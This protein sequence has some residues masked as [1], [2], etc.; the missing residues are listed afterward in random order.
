MREFR[1]KKWLKTS[2]NFHFVEG[3]ISSPLMFC[4][5]KVNMKIKSFCF[6]F[7]LSLKIMEPNHKINKEAKEIFLEERSL[8]ILKM[9]AN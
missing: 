7:A 9:A 3:V 8:Q 2:L 5:Q 1:G 6:C 4:F